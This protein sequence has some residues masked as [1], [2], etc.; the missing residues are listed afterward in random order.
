MAA[1][2][3]AL[4]AS[5]TDPA[6]P[7]MDAAIAT[8][9]PATGPP[10]G[11]PS[12]GSPARSC[13]PPEQPTPCGP[14]RSTAPT[15]STTS[16]PAA[17]GSTSPT[18]APATGSASSPPPR[19]PPPPPATPR[20]R[21]DSSSAAPTKPPPP[22]QQQTSGHAYPGFFAGCQIC[23]CRGGAPGWGTAR[24]VPVAS[25]GSCQIRPRP[26]CPADDLSLR[27]PAPAWPTSWPDQKPVRRERDPSQMCHSVIPSRPVPTLNPDP[28]GEASDHAGARRGRR[29]GNRHASRHP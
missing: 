2:E 23:E 3:Q 24:L 29:G 5:G 7:Y 11:S 10:H 15:S 27:P 12:S 19:S 16:E 26:A 8:A 6:A 4:T 28:K 25:G 18:P 22:P 21:P 9:S 14:P 17:R 1:V 13:S 20:P